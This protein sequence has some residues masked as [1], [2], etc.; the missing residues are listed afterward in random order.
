MV[1]KLNDAQLVWYHL[2]DGDRGRHVRRFQVDGKPLTVELRLVRVKRDVSRKSG[3]PAVR[4]QMDL[5][6]STALATEFVPPSR[7]EVEKLEKRLNQIIEDE[8][9]D[10]YQM[11]RERDWDLLNIGN[12]LR[13]QTPNLPDIDQAAK[14]AKVTIE[15]VTRLLRTG[16]MIQ[17]YEGAR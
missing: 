1:G 11:S 8:L 9:L 14:N 15:V 12:L 6:L 5:E 4:I 17:P 10:F 7:T 13:K 16:G 2:L 3:P